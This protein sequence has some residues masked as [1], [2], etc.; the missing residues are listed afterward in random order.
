MSAALLEAALARVEGALAAGDAPAAEAATAEV[1]AICAGLE[2]R[3]VRLD[4]A[5][6]RALSARHARCARAAE[7]RRDAL[8]AELGLAAR[9]RQADSA[10]RRNGP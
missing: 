7:L 10:Y 8:A 1:V 5:T 3:G 9:S 6:V 2:A 4:G